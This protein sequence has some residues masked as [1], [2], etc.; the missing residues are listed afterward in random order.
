VERQH[1]GVGARARLVE[2]PQVL[3]ARRLLLG[4]RH[5]GVEGVRLG[6]RECRRAVVD[7]H[8]APRVAPT[9]ATMEELPETDRREEEIRR[10]EALRNAAAAQHEILPGR[11]VG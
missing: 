5:A 10:Q 7:A 11:L 8:V 2:A 1:L 9:G 4:A 6:R 3:D